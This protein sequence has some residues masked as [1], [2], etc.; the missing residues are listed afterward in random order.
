M[1]GLRIVLCT[2]ID[3]ACK[4]KVVKE[5][6]T[7]APRYMDGI[8]IHIYDFWETLKEVAQEKGC[9]GKRETITE[10]PRGTLES[11]REVACYRIGEKFDE[12][13][14]D[15]AVAERSK[16][17]GIVVTRTIAPSPAG[18]IRTLDKTHELFDAEACISVID[19]VER[20]QQGLLSDPV[21]A[22]L[23]LSKEEV[24]LK[25]QEEIVNTEEW[26]K[27]TIG[28]GRHFLLAAN[29]PPET[30]L[31]LLFPSVADTDRKMRV[32]LSFPITHADEAIREKKKEF[33]ARLR[34]NWVVFD[35]WSVT[36]YD[37]A[38]SEFKSAKDPGSLKASRAWLERLGPV[39]VDNDYQLITQSD[40][41]VVYYPSTPVK[42]QNSRGE[43][44]DAEQKVLSAGVVAEMI[45]A[46][47]HQRTVQ[48]L[49]L[50]DKMPSPF[51]FR[52]CDPPIFQT[53]EEFFERLR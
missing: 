29:E 6:Q 36:E 4:L 32:Y 14:R 10:L 8:A 3:K 39:T 16:H 41:I 27:S 33:L 19:N 28:G 49:W 15:V 24:L 50:S 17:V 53:E 40:G 1:K 43:W 45:H 48:A 21:W 26:S 13:I 22:K 7:A 23:N 42:V 38:V 18:F 44:V 37:V 9:V 5:A 35:P 46:K 30:L 51:F 47:N 25:R 20:I 31:G 12:E 2:G 34:K 52:Y 11:M